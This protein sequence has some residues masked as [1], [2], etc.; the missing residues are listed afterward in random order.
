MKKKA[1]CWEEKRCGHE[2]GGRNSDTFICPA[3]TE[4]QF[5]G[6][7]GG[8]CAG[9][10]CWGIVGTYCKGKVQ[11]KMAK[12]ILDCSKCSFFSKVVQ[13]EESSFTREIEDIS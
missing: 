11:G 3:A 4:E 2:P 9:R 13:E 7:N 8:K 5:N 1:N 10:F 12:K 6:V